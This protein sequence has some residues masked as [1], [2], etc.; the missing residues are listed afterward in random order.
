MDYV[1]FGKGEDTLIMLPGLGDGLATVKGMAAA[2]AFTYRMYAEKYRVYILS[3][4]NRMPEGYST[5]DMAD[6]QAEAM[7]VLGIRRAKVLGVS[8]GG[9]IAQHLAADHPKLVE[10]PVLAENAVCRAPEL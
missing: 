4:K 7:R 9:M 5:K 1:V 8:Q 2:L 6:D 10:K 3:R